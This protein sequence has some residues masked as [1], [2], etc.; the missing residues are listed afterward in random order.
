MAVV[1]NFSIGSLNLT[2]V[3]LVMAYQPA[4]DVSG[5]YTPSEFTMAG[6][7]SFDLYNVITVNVD[8]GQ[9]G[10]PGLVV[11]NGTLETLNFT[12]DSSINFLG[13]LT[14]SLDVSATYT[15]S[16]G[17]L[18]IK[19]NAGLTLDWSVL[20][21]WMHPF[22]GGTLSLGQLGF[23]I[24][25]NVNNE[26]SSYVDF[27][28][29]IAGEDVGVEIGFKGNISL[30][31]G[32][33]RQVIPFTNAPWDQSL[34]ALAE[35][36]QAASSSMGSG[37]N[38][39]GAEL[40]LRE[41]GDCAS[42]RNRDCTRPRGQLELPCHAGRA[43]GRDGVLRPNRHRRVPSRRSDDYDRS[44]RRLQPVDPLRRAPAA[45]SSSPAGPT[46]RPACPMHWSS[47]PR[48][49]RRKSTRSQP[50]STTSCRSDPA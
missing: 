14:A 17:I 34:D 50:C 35:A 18:D 12:L 26:S 29:G 40:V 43:S 15:A 47:R 45:R 7:A 36:Y 37:Y 10:Q 11:Q 20:P 28:A 6:S 46:W 42:G 27:W 9:N 30:S 38:I 32:D 16:T 23:E 1:G 22:W 33:P 31:F 44:Q 19:G 8:L 2:N 48:S 39:T 5:V 41:S 3:N 4:S 24:Y 25:V 13:K 21:T 49:A